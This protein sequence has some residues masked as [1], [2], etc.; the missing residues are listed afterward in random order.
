M[1]IIINRKQYNHLKYR[2]IE[3]ELSERQLAR[4]IGV[5]NATINQVIR[6]LS[7]SPRIRLT[8]NFKGLNNL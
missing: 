7:Q 1:K 6:G 5:S 4:N 2:L 3:L 8:T